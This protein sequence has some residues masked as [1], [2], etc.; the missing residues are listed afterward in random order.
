MFFILSSTTILNDDNEADVVQSSQV[1][2]IVTHMHLMLASC[3]TYQ[4]T[5]HFTESH[6]WYLSGALNPYK[7]G[8]DK[9]VYNYKIVTKLYKPESTL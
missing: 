5:H 1:S 3:L 8:C 4:L 2:H 6:R 9:V 7:K